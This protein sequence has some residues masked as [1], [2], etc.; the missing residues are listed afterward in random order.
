MSFFVIAD[1]QNPARLQDS[2]AKL[3][4]QYSNQADTSTY[5]DPNV[6]MEQQPQPQVS[7]DGR[8]AI[9]CNARIDNGKELFE[10]LPKS[11]SANETIS[12]AEIILA[13]YDKWGQH[14]PENLVGDFAFVIWDRTSSSI[15]A[16]RDGMNMRT[17][18]YLRTNGGLC[19]ASEGQQL[20]KHPQY[21]PRVSKTALLGWISGQPDPS[22]SMFEGIETIPA[23]HSLFANRNTLEIRKFWDIDPN[24][25]IRYSRQHDY[26]EHLEEL[27]RRAVTDRLRTPTPVVAS[28]MSGGMD[29]TS[30]TALANQAMDRT[31]QQLLVISHSYQSMASCDETDRIKETLAHL[32]IKHSRFLAAE[33]HSTLDFSQLYPPDLENPGTVLSPRYHDEMAL[34]QDAGAQVLL[35]GSGGDEMAWGHSLS[36]S[37]RLQ[38]GDISVIPE[39]VK[40]C[41]EMALPLLTTLRQLFLS[42]MLP[43]WFKH[44]MGRP[45]SDQKLPDWMPTGINYRR[46]LQ[47][48]L[49]SKGSTQF[50]NP[51]MQARYDALQ[52]SST[53][54]SVRSYGKVGAQY[55]IEV[56]HPFF[57]TRLAEFSFAIPD[58]LWNRKGYPKWL[59]RRTMTGAL[60]HSVCWNQ[61]KVIF[62]NFFAEIIRMQADNIRRILADERLEEM[63]L[64]DTRKLLQA[65]DDV[66]SG[67]RGFSVD[68]LYVLMVQIWFQKYADLFEE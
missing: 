61:Q 57:D 42:P 8:F 33:D 23:G 46:D 13:S 24:R 3:I 47:E 58:D 28:Q 64:L 22:I 27:L 51:V 29:S 5:I 26:Q 68:L 67:Q 15:F 44:A 55:G 37:R 18:C 10:L 39:V 17:L 4:P 6:A 31:S 38:R 34:L 19:L 35:T 65:F 48:Q 7:A 53:I 43:N 50:K 60:P 45:A 30:I 52:W 49:L 40:G 14:C 63:G 21:R 59:L 36:Y 25:Q 54:N 56:R 62:D 66:I 12:D 41:R 9:V 2:L 11:I 16:A 20:I 1:W 32:K